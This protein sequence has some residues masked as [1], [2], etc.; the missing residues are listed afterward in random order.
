MLPSAA[1]RILQILWVRATRALAFRS[2]LTL[3]LQPMVHVPPVHP[4]FPF[5]N[6]VSALRDF[7]AVKLADHAAVRGT[8]AAIAAG[9]I[10]ALVAGRLHLGRTRL[11]LHFFDGGLF[12][13]FS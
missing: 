6:L 9:T 8:F 10:A 11:V 13:T 1:R 5:E 12:I 2:Q 3:R 4:P 7:I